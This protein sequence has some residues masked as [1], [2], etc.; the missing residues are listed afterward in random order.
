MEIYICKSG[1]SGYL[2]FELKTHEFVLKIKPT[3]FGCKCTCL[4]FVAAHNGSYLQKERRGAVEIE[5][6]STLAVQS[7]PHANKMIFYCFLA[8]HH[9]QNGT[10]KRLWH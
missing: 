1:S 6:A 10:P 7:S 2:L 9:S 5:N 4:A 3:S 8:A